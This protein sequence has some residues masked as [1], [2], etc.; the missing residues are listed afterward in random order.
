M[1]GRGQMF[2]SVRSLPKIEIQGI[3]LIPGPPM[4]NRCDLSWSTIHRVITQ[5]LKQML[6]SQSVN[7]LHEVVRLRGTTRSMAP[8]TLPP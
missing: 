7:I 5:F 6:Y 8:V 2:Q 3:H 4:R 1:F